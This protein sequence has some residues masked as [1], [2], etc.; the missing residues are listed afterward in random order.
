MESIGDYLKEKVNTD[1]CPAMLVSRR[2]I[3]GG[4]LR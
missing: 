4:K 3:S 2:T 1:N